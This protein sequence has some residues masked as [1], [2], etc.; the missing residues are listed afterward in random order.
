MFGINPSIITHCLNIDPN[1]CLVK[2]QQR[3]FTL[4]HYKAIKIK[5]DKLLKDGFIRSVDYLTWLSNM[6]LVKKANEQW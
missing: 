1:H 6:V 3:I 5:V 2:Q 4:E